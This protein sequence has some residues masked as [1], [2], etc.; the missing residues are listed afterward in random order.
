MARFVS[1][2]SLRT[3]QSAEDQRPLLARSASGDFPHDERKADRQQQ[4]FLT[5][6]P[7]SVYEARSGFSMENGDIIPRLAVSSTT[8]NDRNVV[9][10]SNF[11]P[12]FETPSP[13]IIKRRKNSPEKYY[14]TLA[15]EEKQTDN[16]QSLP[17][18]QTPN[19]SFASIGKENEQIGP[20]DE[21]TPFVGRWLLCGDMEP[22]TDDMKKRDTTTDKSRHH[23]I[24]EDETYFVGSWRD[25]LV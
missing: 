25:R 18:Q 12:S 15:E 22:W 5:K 9:S 14:F 24:A 11:M 20:D 6:Y 8:T 2:V 4:C 19:D 1:P 17:Q 21:E 16:C 13:N 10:T 23:F 3:A 7:V